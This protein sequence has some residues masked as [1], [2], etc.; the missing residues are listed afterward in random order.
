MRGAVE[1]VGSSLDVRIGRGL[2]AAQHGP[3]ASTRKKLS[4]S[5]S[6]PTSPSPLKSG[7]PQAAQQ[8]PARQAKNASMS[9]SVAVSPS[10]LK[11]ALQVRG[12]VA[13]SARLLT[14]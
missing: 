13:S 11:S 1:A 9:A 3:P 14:S 6:A 5:A 7:E 4:M 2:S 8:L 10:P 12:Q